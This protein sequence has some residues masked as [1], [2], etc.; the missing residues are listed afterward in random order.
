M[1]ISGSDATALVALFGLDAAN[2]LTLDNLS[3]LYRVTQLLSVCR[4]SFTD[5]QNLAPLINTGAANTATAITDIFSSVAAATNFLQQIKA[6]QQSGFS[7]DA[8]V[9]LLTKPAATAPLWNATSAMTDASI[10]TALAAVRQAILNPSGGD[11]NGGVMAAVASQLGIANDI[12][13]FIMQG[14]NLPATARTLL[15]VLTDASITSPA[16]G[17]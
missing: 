11:V 4:I 7:I 3:L 6:V 12:T 5:L 14:I 17:P 8:L 15:N 16:G 1:G 10:S 2:T 13:S 9:Y